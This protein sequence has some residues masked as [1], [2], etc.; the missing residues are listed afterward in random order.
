LGVHLAE[1]VVVSCHP[2][3]IEAA[4]Q[5]EPSSWIK[6]FLILAFNEGEVVFRRVHAEMPVEE[7]PAHRISINRFE[8]TDFGSSFKFDWTV[9]G[10]TD[11]FYKIEGNLEVRPFY[12]DSIVSII[13]SATSAVDP[14][15]WIGAM[16]PAEVSLRILLGL[17]RAAFERQVTLPATWPE[18]APSIPGLPNLQ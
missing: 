12:G 14:A 6:P 18:P 2:G 17:L 16:R 3:T 1:Q 9:V 15:E 13:G 5:E 11:P 10:A 7:S 4:L 8:L